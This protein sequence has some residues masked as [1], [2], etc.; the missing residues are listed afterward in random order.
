M[1]DGKIDDTEVK[2]LRKELYADGKIDTA[3]VKFLIDL[4]EA[5]QKKAKARN[6]PVGAAFEKLFFKAIEDNV[7]KDGKIDA[8]EVRWLRD[9]LFAD[10]K[11]DANERKFLA[12]L[13]KKAKSVHDSFNKLYDDA[14]AK[15]GKAKC[16][17]NGQRV[18]PA[19][20]SPS[21]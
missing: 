13:K 4:R 1:A 21:T 20:P 7:L 8:A 19:L 14:M 16:Q 18:R 11:I 2:V 3:E 12:S 5:A 9:M 15:A 10:G 6:A 17:S